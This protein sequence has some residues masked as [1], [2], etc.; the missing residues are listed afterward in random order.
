MKFAN[1]ALDGIDG[2]MELPDCCFEAIGLLLS[3]DLLGPTEHNY[4]L[5]RIRPEVPRHFKLGRR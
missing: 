5:A 1:G 4:G 2:L 3:W